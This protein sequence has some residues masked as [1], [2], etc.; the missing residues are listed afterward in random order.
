MARHGDGILHSVVII[1]LIMFSTIAT[2]VYA[3]EQYI[4]VHTG[5]GTWRATRPMDKESC[6]QFMGVMV[7]AFMNTYIDKGDL[8]SQ[9]DEIGI[10]RVQWKT[11]PDKSTLF[12]LNASP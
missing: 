7:Q 5:F 12:F 3:D 9:T 1:G 8:M 10:Y 4:G 11:S 6:Q 2:H